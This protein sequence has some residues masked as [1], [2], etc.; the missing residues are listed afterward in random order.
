[1]NGYRFF[2]FGLALLA[3]LMLFPGSAAARSTA[4]FSME[5]LV[6]GIPLAQ[7]H[8]RN[9][10]YIEA[11]EGREYTV[12]LIN[13]T[14][15]RVAVALSVDGMNSIDAKTTSAREAAKWILGPYQTVTLD[16]W[17]TGADSARRF[18]FTTEQNS[19]GAWMGKTQNLGVIAAAVFRERTPQPLPIESSKIQKRGRRSKAAGEAMD[20]PQSALSDDLAATG[21]GQRFDHRVRKIEFQSEAAPFVVSTLR[22]EYHDTL[23]RLGVLP[24]SYARYEDPLQRRENARG[25]DDFDF[26][27]EP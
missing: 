8:A 19:Y 14:G 22:Y 15:G 18:F 16:G 2:S 27:P 6:D 5:I 7:H 17:Q 20:A 21:M 4:P 10:T 25:F 13:R 26:A 9:A 24:P 1:M 23:V 12:R 3:L 11:L